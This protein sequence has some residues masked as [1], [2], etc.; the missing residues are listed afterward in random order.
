MQTVT[1]YNVA[2]VTAPASDNI[3][4]DTNGLKLFRILVAKSILEIFFVSALAVGFFLSA[5]PP[6]FHGWGE[7]TPKSIEGWVVNN[8]RPWDRVEVQ[9]FIDGHFTSTGIANTPRPDVLS[10]GWARDQWHGYV[11]YLPKL[12]PG[13][14][15]ARV[16]AVHESGGGTRQTLQ[17]V[18]DAIYFSSD[19]NGKLV[20]LNSSK[21]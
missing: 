20:D 3:R 11:F 1:V 16:Y 10:A 13:N 4:M 7:A 2:S 18:G 6:Y 5:F 21:R 19:H 15:E 17:L 14:H 9:L 8:A 12:P